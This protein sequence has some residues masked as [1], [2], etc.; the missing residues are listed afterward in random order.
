MNIIPTTHKMTSR[1]RGKTGG[2]SIIRNTRVKRDVS[3][4]VE[5]PPSC[6]RPGRATGDNDSLNGNPAIHKLPKDER[7]AGSN[8]Q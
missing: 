8:F 2:G 6:L 3:L 7:V 4:M 5:I 1:P